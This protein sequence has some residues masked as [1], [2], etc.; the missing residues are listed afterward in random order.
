[1]YVQNLYL[2]S[3]IYLNIWFEERNGINNYCDSS[4]KLMEEIIHCKY[5]LITSNLII[6]ELAKKTDQSEETIILNFMKP[7]ISLSKYEMEKI[8]QKI[9]D[10]AAYFCGMYGI[11][12]VDAIHAMIAQLN[13]CYLVT[14]DRDLIF[15]AKEYGVKTYRPEDLI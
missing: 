3:N 12:K 8:T 1:M 15:A 7:F 11:H 2:D 10:D 5:K 4:L 6:K 9:A 13:D 14:R